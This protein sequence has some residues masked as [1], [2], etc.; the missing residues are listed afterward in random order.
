VARITAGSFVSSMI[1]NTWG[2]C[3]FLKGISR[4]PSGFDSFTSSMNRA[5]WAGSSSGC[6]SMAIRMP[7]AF[8]MARIFS[9]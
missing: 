9:R 3:P 7:R 4:R 5:T 6:S 1:R 2:Q 8:S